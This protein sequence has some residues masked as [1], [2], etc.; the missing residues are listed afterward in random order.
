MISLLDVNVLI[1][2]LD[3]NHPSNGAANEYFKQA[4]RKGWATCPL[5]QNGVLRIMGHP[6]YH[7]GA[8]SVG[9]VRDQLS[10]YLAAP[11]HQ[12]W[13]DD[14]SLADQRIF[15]EMSASKGLTDLYLLGLAVKRRGRF[16]TFDRRIDPSLLP[17]GP[18]AYHVLAQ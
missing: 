12:F 8:G 9:P 6:N 18:A 5:T 4:Q 15:P 14:L 16:V 3:W 13:P 7:K 10:Y 17:S 11:G 1:A 2:L